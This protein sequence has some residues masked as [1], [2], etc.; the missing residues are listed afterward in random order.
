MDCNSF[1]KK[2]YVDRKNTD[3]IKWDRADVKDKLPMFIADMDFKT[4]DK[5][6]EGMR[7]KINH[8]TFGYAVLPKDYY[9][10]IIKWNKKRN[11]VTLKKEWF[12]FSKGAVDGIY[13]V[14][15]AFTKAKDSILITDPVYPPFSATVKKTGRNLITSRLV[16]KDGLYTFNYDDIE[17]KIK[18]KKI[19][20]M[21]L[22]TPHNPLGRVWTKDELAKLFK[23]T[24]KYHVLVISDEVHSDLI[25]PGY[26]FVQSLA[27]KEYQDD[28]ITIS[29]ASKTFSLAV[30]AHCHI[31]IPNKKLKAKF[32][33]YQ[34]LNHLT[35]P[36]AINAYPTYLGY[37]Y[38]ES[39]LEDCMNVINENYKYFC[40][41][42]SKYVEILPMQGTY[43]AFVNFKGYTKN[44]AKF[45]DQK[46]GIIAN[47]GE[48]FCKD[49]ATWA[50]INL[51][52]SLDNIK[53]AC[54]KIE[55]ALNK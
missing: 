34:E 43:L 14:V 48:T 13:Q 10:P 28:I 16:V 25:M 15:Y 47:A 7:N 52:T 5:I 24:H 38:G 49:Y 40:S 35:T 42:L 37:K 36:N 54:D 19:K 11:K 26:K 27:F 55:K 50:R 29:A 46:C 21:I 23:I 12:A 3:S 30:Y 17:K 4:E 20:M 51:A 2:Y 44:A 22:C 41:R 8:G 1:C 45:L 9:E 33:A 6:V 39:W 18:Q 32:D 31:I 53:L